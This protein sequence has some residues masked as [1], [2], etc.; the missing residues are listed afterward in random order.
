MRESL[1]AQCFADAV[2]E[3]VIN[4]LRGKLFKSILKGRTHVSI[5]MTADAA[6]HKQQESVQFAFG[7]QTGEGGET[8]FVWSPP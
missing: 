7:A 4:E 8:A 2:S 1:L 5:V 3:N 6:V